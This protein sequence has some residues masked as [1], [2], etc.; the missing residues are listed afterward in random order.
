M[1]VQYIGMFDEVFVVEANTTAR[2]GMPI[3][4]ADDL[5]ARLCEQHENWRPSGVPASLRGRAGRQGPSAAGG[6][7]EAVLEE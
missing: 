5:G 4:V 3:E 6:D 2:K 7:T 1:K